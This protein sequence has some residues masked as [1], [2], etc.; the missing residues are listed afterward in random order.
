MARPELIEL[1]KGLQMKQEDVAKLTGIDRRTYNKIE[2][3]SI[4]KPSWEMVGRISWALY[5]D[6]FALF[7]I[8]RIK[9]RSA[10]L[11]VKRIA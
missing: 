10:D 8:K 7:P 6:P 4:K 3:G 2:T 5:A 9:K 1:R 11:A